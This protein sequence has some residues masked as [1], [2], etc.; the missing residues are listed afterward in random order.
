MGD[1]PCHNVVVQPDLALGQLR[2]RIGEVVAV[3]QL[4]DALPAEDAEKVPD[5]VCPDDPGPF[6]A[7]AHD[8]SPSTTR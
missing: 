5:L 8:Y 1:H 4:I 7:H 3:G 6:V 2:D